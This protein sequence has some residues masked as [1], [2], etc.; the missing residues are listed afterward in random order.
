[1]VKT[2]SFNDLFSHFNENVMIQ[3]IAWCTEQLSALKQD[4]QG[5]GMVIYIHNIQVHRRTDKM[6]EC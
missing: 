4:V 5:K 3:A 1:M 6:I 2:L